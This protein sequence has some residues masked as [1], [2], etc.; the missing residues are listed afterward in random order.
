[1]LADL[2]HRVVLMDQKQTQGQGGRMVET[3]PI[4]AE[5]WA[6]VEN[7]SAQFS[8]RQARQYLADKIQITIPYAPS[9]MA[10]KVIGFGG[11]QYQV[12]SISR[13]HSLQPTIRIEAYN[14]SN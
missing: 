6:A 14:K 4:I 1:M 11:C 9:L 7:A 8:D 5:A 2:R 13:S 3:T 12:G 10:T